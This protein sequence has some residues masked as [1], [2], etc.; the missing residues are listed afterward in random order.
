MLKYKC[1]LNS[2]ITVFFCQLNVAIVSLRDLD[3]TV[4]WNPL[5]VYF[6]QECQI[7]SSIFPLLNINSIPI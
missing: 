7:L 3:G 5:K 1:I 4:Y 2:N 6:I